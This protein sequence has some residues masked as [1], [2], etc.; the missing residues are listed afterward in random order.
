MADLVA[1]S[2]NEGVSIGYCLNAVVVEM[3]LIAPFRLVDKV[4]GLVA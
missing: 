3:A 4:V 2:E 1:S